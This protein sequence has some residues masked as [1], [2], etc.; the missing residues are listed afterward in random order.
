[1][2]RT[3]ETQKDRAARSRRESDCA[4]RRRHGNDDATSTPQSAGDFVE[5]GFWNRATPA[6]ETKAVVA[7]P[8]F[9]VLRR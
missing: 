7:E 8:A 2:R 3:A 6:D 1:M 4:F 9:L 5:C